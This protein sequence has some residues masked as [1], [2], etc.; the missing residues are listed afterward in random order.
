MP[1]EDLEAPQ[2]QR[3][4]LPKIVFGLGLGL[5]AV[6]G[7]MFYNASAT[8]PPAAPEET[9]A[10]VGQPSGTSAEESE[11][12]VLTLLGTLLLGTQDTQAPAGPPR[13]EL[14]QAAFPRA[15]D[16]WSLMVAEGSRQTEAVVRAVSD[17]I[18]TPGAPLRVSTLYDL[19]ETLQPD[20][21]ATLDDAY[22]QGRVYVSGETFVMVM[23]RRLPPEAVAKEN[24]LQGDLSGPP[25]PQEIAGRMFMES[26]GTAD[27]DAIHALRLDI[28]EDLFIEIGGRVDRATLRRFAEGI[29]YDAL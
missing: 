15:P 3:K 27:S 14:D 12:G 24:W 16:G 22:D 29:D 21:A 26:A 10:A 4:L 6:A 7:V 1:D 28:A 19:V 23:I 8:Q 13:G 9:A 11:A 25:V 2:R 20:D 5:L 17:A 18:F